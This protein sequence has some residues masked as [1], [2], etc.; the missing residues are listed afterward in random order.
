MN[1]LDILM[2]AILCYSLIMGCF[3]GLIRELTAIAGVL[4]GFFIGYTYYKEVAR[5]FSRWLSDPVYL[6]ILGFMALFCT[7]FIIA[8]LVG[9]LLKYF[10]ETAFGKGFDRTCGAGFGLIKGWLIISVL[11]VVLVAFLPRNAPV[12]R[13]SRLAP[14]VTRLSEKMA[15]VVP[16]EMKRE[17]RDRLSQLKQA[18]QTSHPSENKPSE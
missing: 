1:A 7:V 10:V 12:M 18:W 14:Y 5:V 11:L 6:K 15:A 17:F 4:G 9:I 3:R 8:G 2:V 13:E 16:W